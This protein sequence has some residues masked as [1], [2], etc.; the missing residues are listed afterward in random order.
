MPTKHHEFELT[1]YQS[2]VSVKVDNEGDVVNGLTFLLFNNI[3]GIRVLP[4]LNRL[5]F[6]TE[7]HKG[8]LSEEQKIDTVRVSL[9]S[10]D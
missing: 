10:F 3:M 1:E 6:E 7:K 2:I 5:K 8:I 9:K 4:R